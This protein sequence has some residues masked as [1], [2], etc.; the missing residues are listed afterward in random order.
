M[1]MSLSTK[2]RR[3]NI[4]NPDTYCGIYCGACSIAMYSKTG[5]ADEFVACLGGVPKEELSCGGCKSDNIY[6]GCKACGLRRCAREKG[7]E[8]CIDCA[9]YPCKSYRTW[10]TVAKL[11]PHLHGAAASLKNIKLDGVDHWLD[12]QKKRWSCP[13]CGTSFS[14]YATACYKCGRSLASKAHEL[15]GWRKLLCRFMLTMAYRKGR[16]ENKIV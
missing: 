15:S 1:K 10:Q 3:M 8:H 9:D 14:W 2:V 16:A 12:V 13:D 11:L 4:V 7:I 5:R 6:A